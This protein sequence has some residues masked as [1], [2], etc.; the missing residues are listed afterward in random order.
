LISISKKLQNKIH[1]NIGEWLYNTHDVVK[2]RSHVGLFNFQCYENAVQFAKTHKSS[3]VIMGIYMERGSP[4]LHFWNTDSNG[5]HI[6]TTRGWRAEHC[7][8]YPLRVIPEDDYV[9]IGEIFDEALT[10]FTKQ[11]TTR[12]QRFIL[13]SKRVM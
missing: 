9:C 8:Y 3:T 13:G 1:Y 11:F 2:V 10:Y 6:E 12:W 5:D 7:T 4:V